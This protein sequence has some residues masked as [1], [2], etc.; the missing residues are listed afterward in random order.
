M[1]GKR[2]TRQQYEIYMKLKRSGLSQVTSSAKA[3]FSERTGRNLDKRRGVAL[4]TRNKKIG[5]RKNDPLEAWQGI[6]LPL[7]LELCQSVVK[8]GR[9]R[10]MEL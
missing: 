4:S 8:T 2:I 6:L 7:I 9:I 5:K 10:G 3:G 1:P